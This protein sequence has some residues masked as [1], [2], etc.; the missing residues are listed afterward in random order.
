VSA[1]EKHPRHIEPGSGPGCDFPIAVVAIIVALLS[2]TWRK[3]KA[4][5]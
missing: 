4:A 2:K 1:H 3:H 5:Q